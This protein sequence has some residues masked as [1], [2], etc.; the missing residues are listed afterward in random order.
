M[1]SSRS[2]TPAEAAAARLTTAVGAWASTIGPGAGVAVALSGGRDS[3]A[4]LHATRAATAGRIALCAL[5]VHHGL[6]PDADR[7]MAFCADACARLGVGFASR[8]VRVERS[9]RTSLEERAR[10][11]RYQ[12]LRELAFEHGVAIVALAHHQDD[13]AETL[14][15]QLARGAGP[16]GLAAMPAERIDAEGLV[17]ARPLLG[18]AR[19]DI[20][21]YTGV[22]ALAWVDDPSN[23]DPRHRRN[24]VRL[25]V[26]PAIAAAMPGYPATLARA[27]R[28]QADAAALADALAEIDA[29]AAGCDRGGLDCAALARL[30]GAR[31]R[32]LLRWWLR[33]AGL[34]PPSAAR[35][36]QIAAQLASP[37]ADAR[38]AIAHA[39]RVIGRHRGR[40]HV[41]PEAPPDYR[42]DWHGEPTIAL[43]H[44]ELAFVPARGEGIDAGRLA[45]GL[46]VRPRRGG[47]RMRLR[48]GGPLRSLKTLLQQHGV[49]S[50]DRDALPLVVAGD[51]LVA[52]PGIGVDAG[53]R[54]PPGHPGFVPV[55]RDHAGDGRP[56]RA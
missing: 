56:E 26:A 50:W 45:A 1:A 55:W 35:L 4:L 17:W 28:H 51:A 36:D 30:S 47:E 25:A 43:P 53:W 12:A 9:A 3:M 23:H 14:L 33:D 5:H 44:G 39:G 27:A 52:A 32:N 22:H 21:A 20:D 38:I 34:P 19:A 49:P 6:S 8:R 42:R 54:A 15:L 31:A 40:A 48:I 13:Q 10:A 37:R 11:A 24:A 29:I 16:Q 7:W 18:V 41:H 46:A 2:S